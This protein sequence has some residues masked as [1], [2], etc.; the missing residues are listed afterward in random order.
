MGKASTQTL[1]PHACFTWVSRRSMSQACSISIYAHT[2]SRT[3]RSCPLHTHTH[4]GG[5]SSYSRW[6]L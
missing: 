3:Y 6:L 2:I 5:S 4:G 1:V